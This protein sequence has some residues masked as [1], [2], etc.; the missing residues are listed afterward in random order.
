M[1]G[2]RD[3]SDLLWMCRRAGVLTDGVFS[4][5]GSR[6]HRLRVR[7]RATRSQEDAAVETTQSTECERGTPQTAS[8]AETSTPSAVALS[9]R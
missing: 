3:R 2:M 1:Q 4:L 7:S 9:C 5:A 8:C 6:A